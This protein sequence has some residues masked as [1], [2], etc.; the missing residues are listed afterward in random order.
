[1]KGEVIEIKDA[2]RGE[3]VGTIL[4]GYVVVIG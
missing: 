1:M 2:D 4:L 3:Y